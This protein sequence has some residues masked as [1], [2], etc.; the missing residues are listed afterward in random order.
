MA[1]FVDF[2]SFAR[3]RHVADPDPFGTFCRVLEFW[4]TVYEFLA[5]QTFLVQH[6]ILGKPAR[7]V[8]VND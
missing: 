3:F 7:I 4:T 8:G 1:T 2:A 6:R 5:I